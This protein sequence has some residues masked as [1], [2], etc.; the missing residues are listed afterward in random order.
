M[1]VR[2]LY[3]LIGLILASL[4]TPRLNATPTNEVSP[5]MSEEHVTTESY[6]TFKSDKKGKLAKRLNKLIFKAKKF[7]NK[8]AQK[9][10]LEDPVSKWLW[11]G[12]IA[13]A[14]AVILYILAFLTFGFLSWFAYMASLASSVCFIIWLVKYLEV[15]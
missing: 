7:G 4:F 2:L 10:D 1:K 13:L 8:L 3:T 11:Y 12:V 15:M 5:S 6:T 14:A 9:I